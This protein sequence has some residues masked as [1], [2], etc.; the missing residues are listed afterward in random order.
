MKLLNFSLLTMMKSRYL[1]YNDIGTEL[2][3]QN[4]KTVKD[5]FYGGI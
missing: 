2:Y 4:E 3:V 5:I 1:I